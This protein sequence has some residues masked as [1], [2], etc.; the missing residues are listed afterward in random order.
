MNEQ[1]RILH[2]A[3]SRT[4]SARDRHHNSPAADG[5]AR[6][7]VAATRRFAAQ[8][9]LSVLLPVH[10]DQARLVPWISQ[11]LEVLPELTPRWNLLIVDDGS[12]DATSEVAH[13]LVKHYPQVELLAYPRTMSTAAWQRAAVSQTSG[14]TILLRGLASTLALRDVPKLWRALGTHDVVRARSDARAPLGWIPRLPG[15]RASDR[16]PPGLSLVRRR[17][18]ESWQR[19]GTDQPLEVFLMRSDLDGC[20]VSVRDQATD[21]VWAPRFAALEQSGAV[22]SKAP[23]RR[24]EPR[25][26]NYLARLKAFALGE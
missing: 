8:P 12:T 11:L 1:I 16:D 21:N 10:N 14:E 17:A 6:P 5:A 7:A 23:A 13:D 25:R 2:L 4:D 15:A 19:S 3:S 22:Y 9:S 20:D 18:I 24:G 26:P